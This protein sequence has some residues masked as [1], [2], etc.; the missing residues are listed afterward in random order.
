M[1]RPRHSLRRTQKTNFKRDDVLVMLDSHDVT[2]LN[3]DLACALLD[4]HFVMMA[5]A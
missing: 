3:I 5:T 4:L 2:T 1:N